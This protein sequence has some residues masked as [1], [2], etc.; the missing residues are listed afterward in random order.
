MAT[1]RKIKDLSTLNP[2]D[3]KKQ[4]RKKRIWTLVALV[5]LA[6]TVFGAYWATNPDL[7]KKK[8]K[9]TVEV[10]HSDHSVDTLEITT[11]EDMLIDAWSAILPY[12]L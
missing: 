2:V 4:T 10:H 5:L 7:F 9:F 11:K 6:A 8:T 12:L 3:K 1:Y